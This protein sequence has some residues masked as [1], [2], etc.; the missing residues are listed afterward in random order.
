MSKIVYVPYFCLI[1]DGEGE[2]PAI[3]SAGQP[4]HARLSRAPRSHLRRLIAAAMAEPQS[5]QQA[6]SPASAASAGSVLL[7]PG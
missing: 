2:K 1:E 3:V 4:R 7:A 5:L 6:A